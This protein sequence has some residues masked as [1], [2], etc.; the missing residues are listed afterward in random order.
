[1]ILEHDLPDP[2]TNNVIDLSNFIFQQVKETG[3]KIT[4]ILNAWPFQ[5]GTSMG[6]WEWM[7]VSN[8]KFSFKYIPYL[9]QLH[10]SGNNLESIEPLCQM[11]LPSLQLLNIGNLELMQDG[12][13]FERLLL[14]EKL[15]SHL[16]NSYIYVKVVEQRW[17][18][19]QRLFM[20]KLI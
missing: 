7:P 6:S 18:W 17:E 8:R 4:C 20:F 14:C 12:I 9:Q 2:N 15:F 19:V 3:G 10:F 13:T 11:F 16:F 5:S 1:M